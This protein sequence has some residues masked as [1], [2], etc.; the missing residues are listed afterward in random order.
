MDI[1]LIEIRDFL[2][3]NHPFDLLPDNELDS[4]PRFL[5]LA[6]VRRDKPLFSTGEKSEYLY[7]V[8]TGAVEVKDTQG[9]VLSRRGEGDSVG[10]RALV[11]GHTLYNVSTIEDTL[12]YKLPKYK[13]RQLCDQYERFAYYY[14]VD[15]ST[16]L[17]DA[18]KLPEASEGAHSLNLMTTAISE[19]MTQN[20]VR[21]GTEATVG[22]AARKMTDQ[23]ASAVFI[24]DGQRLLGIVTE[25]DM[26]SRCLASD[27]PSSTPL[28]EIMT[29]DPHP[30]PSDNYAFQAMMLM[31]RCNIR[32]LPVMDNQQQLVGI[33][34]AGELVQRQSTSP[35]YLV[36]DIYRQTSVEHL[37]DVARAIPQA[38]LNLVNADATAHSIGHMISSIGDA[39]TIQLIHFAEQ[40]LGPAPVSFAWMSFGS[41]ARMEQSARSDQDNGLLLA[42][43]Y[44]EATHGEYFIQLAQFVS[45]GLNA[46]GYEYCPGD[47][48]ATNPKWRQPLGQWKKYFSNWIQKPERKALM[49]A[50]IFFDMRAVHGDNELF[51]ELHQH[52]LKQCAGNSIFLAHL[53]G[54]ALHLEPP[55]GF[56]RRFVLV[57]DG[58]HDKTLDLKHNGVVPIIDLARIYALARSVAAVNTRSRL[59]A[60]G[61]GGGEV[62]PR[63]AQDLRDALELISMI[64]LRHQARQIREG[65]SADNFI[66]P[67]ELSNFDRNHLKDAFEIVRTMQSA[68]GQRFQAGRF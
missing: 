67:E 62:S 41:L 66:P 5:E 18:V 53:T 46:C 49:H 16:R 42:E 55:L 4:L 31:S 60:V 8:R 63:G 26:C 25:H 23:G 1:E 13:F 9:E 54:N 3:A 65:G 51:N 61:S 24:C 12:L 32:H 20:F 36:S 15:G 40:K 57:N 34:S 38:L 56:F 37:A 48:M 17:H 33:V 39:I 27:L 59:E 10:A 45:D 50:S 58:Q 68:L 14:H 21:L 64:R 28:T 43:D 6:Y 7:I 35:V 30:I 22:E 52:V 2:A 29:H 19:L 11:R 47:I 44:D